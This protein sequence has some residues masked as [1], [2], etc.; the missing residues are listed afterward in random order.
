M[1]RNA[2]DDAFAWA[3]REPG[4]VLFAVQA[5]SAWQ[6]VPAAQF[7]SRVDAVAAGLVATGISPGDRVG[8]IAPTCLDWLVCDFS[9]WAAGA[10][11]VP[12]Y[13]TSSIEQIHWQLSDSGAVAVFAGNEQLAEAVRAS[14][15]AK[16]KATWRMDAGGLDAVASA[17][18]SLATRQVASRRAA[19]TAETLATIVYTSGTTGRA[20]GCMISHGNL[21][22]AVR[23]DVFA[24]LYASIV[25][26]ECFHDR[27]LGMSTALSS[28]MTF[29]PAWLTG[30][31]SNALRSYAQ[32]IP[33]PCSD[34]ADASECLSIAGIE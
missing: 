18:Q 27:L 31:G 16:V 33:P 20:K 12:I 19:V 34:P 24:C 32:T 25:I 4:R 17:G 22:Q 8:L 3:D 5:D 10:V 7:A 29:A 28:S 21:T 26:Y 23:G 11:T 9:I 13:E 2:C 14:K 15:P 30:S 1:G 6:P